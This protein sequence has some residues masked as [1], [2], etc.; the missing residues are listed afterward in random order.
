MATPSKTPRN[1]IT[2]RDTSQGSHGIVTHGLDTPHYVEIQQG[3][4]WSLQ[5]IGSNDKPVFVE[6]GHARNVTKAKRLAEDAVKQLVA[7][8]DAQTQVTKTTEPAPWLRTVKIYV[9]LFLT[10]L[11]VLI[12]GRYLL[13]NQPRM[14]ARIVF[15][16]GA[17][18][19]LSHRI[20]VWFVDMA[21]RVEYLTGRKT[22]P[23]TVQATAQ[24]MKMPSLP[25]AKRP[26]A[27]PAGKR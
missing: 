11:A 26:K 25:A 9:G 5:T 6:R 19:Y 10:V 12:F 4:V 20:I 16:G 8:D 22:S 14:L 1:L 15:W 3:G 2:W 21:R 17:S 13:F 7:P 27:L 23:V 24:P 18:A